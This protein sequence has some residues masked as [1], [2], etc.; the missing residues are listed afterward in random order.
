MVGSEREVTK[1]RKYPWNDIRVFHDS[2]FLARVQRLM[3]D[4]RA[5]LESEPAFQNQL[6]LY[7]ELGSI[8]KSKGPYRVTLVIDVVSIVNMLYCFPLRKWNS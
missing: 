2:G 8:R 4:I 6:Q 7:D 3:E 1:S 5:M